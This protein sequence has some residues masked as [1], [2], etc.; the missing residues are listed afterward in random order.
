[1][2]PKK[3]LKNDGLSITVS[4]TRVVIGPVKTNKIISPSELVYNM[5]KPIS[6]LLG[7][8]MLLGL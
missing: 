5:L 7:L 3:A 6:T 1:M 4:G 2:Y 8:R